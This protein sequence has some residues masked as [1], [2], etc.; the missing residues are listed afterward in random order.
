MD[1]GVGGANQSAAQNTQN[2][3]SPRHKPSPRTSDVHREPSGSAPTESSKRN[4]HPRRSNDSSPIQS[5]RN[6]LTTSI[7]E[8]SRPIRQGRR[9]AKF[10]ATLTDPSTSQHAPTTASRKG[11]AVER[12]G[13]DL[14][15]TLIHALSTPPYPDC[16]ICFNA[17]HPDHYTWSCSPSLLSS[18]TPDVI[19]TAQCCWTTFHLHCIRSWSTKSVKEVVDAWRARGEERPGQW[20]CPGCQLKREILPNGYWYEIFLSLRLIYQFLQVF[21]WLYSQT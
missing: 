9:G 7:T 2:L 10:N 4:R 16:P 11:N 3:H 20:R 8:K 19:S 17:I 12:K 6:T 1:A 15:S 5:T 13:D 14:T 18:D 21:L